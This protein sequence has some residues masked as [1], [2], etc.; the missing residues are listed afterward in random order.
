MM[1]HLGKKV[2]IVIVAAAAAANVCLF[3]YSHA[4]T[5]FNTLVDGFNLE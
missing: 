2:T 1:M 5:H 4:S 3:V